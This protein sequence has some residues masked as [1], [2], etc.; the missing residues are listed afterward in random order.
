MTAQW[1]PQID[2]MKC[3]GCRNCIANCP[4]A[5]LGEENGKAAL[6]RPD[7]CTYCAACEDVCPA[8]AIELPFLI[9]KHR[10]EAID[11]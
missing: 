7:L 6:L 5:A 9:V 2:R 8:G 3:T 10:E 4:T 11:E 1:M